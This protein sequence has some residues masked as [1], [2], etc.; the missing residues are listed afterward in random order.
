M[1][2]LA[3]PATTSTG[4]GSVVMG[5]AMVAQADAMGNRGAQAGVRSHVRSGVSRH[6]PSGLLLDGCAAAL[7]ALAAARGKRMGRVRRERRAVPPGH[8]ASLA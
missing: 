4:V 1:R 6:V 2:R 8:F 3:P 7:H 5:V